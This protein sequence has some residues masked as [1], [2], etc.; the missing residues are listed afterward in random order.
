MNQT[1]NSRR[2]DR[3]R[4]FSP[5]RLSAESVAL[6]VM[7]GVVRKTD[8]VH[9]LPA[10]DAPIQRLAVSPRYQATVVG[11]SW[12]WIVRLLTQLRPEFRSGAGQHSRR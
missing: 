6:L 5:T 11:D 8:P 2:N 10:T 12:R 9:P 4:K 1:L 3:R 7:N